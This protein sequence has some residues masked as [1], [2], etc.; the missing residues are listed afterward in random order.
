MTAIGPINF[1]DYTSVGGI[2]PIP[3]IFSFSP[4][5][6]T[7]DQNSCSTST[8]SKQRATLESALS[9]DFSLHGLATIFVALRQNLSCFQ[10]FIGFQT[11][12]FEKKTMTRISIGGKSDKFYKAVLLQILS[13]RWPALVY[14]RVIL[15]AEHAVL[16]QSMSK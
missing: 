7:T 4:P 15:R 5:F 1:L 10:L 11:I 14:Q 8:S 3:P 12:R 16:F 2:P 13:T 9:G 6:S